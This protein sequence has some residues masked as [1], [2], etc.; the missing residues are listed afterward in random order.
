MIFLFIVPIALL[1]IG[2]ADLPSGYYVFLRIVVCLV[3][4]LSCY[5]SYKSNEKVGI[6]T[7]LFALLAVLFNPI[8]P[9]YLYDKDIWTVIDI[10][11]AVLL[12]IR[13]FTLM[14]KN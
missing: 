11:A 10:S 9:I 3:S 1:L 7:I 2:L 4:C 12:G 13:G 8:I 5:W 14:N 6:A